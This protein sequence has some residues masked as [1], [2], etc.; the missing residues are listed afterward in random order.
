MERLCILY[1][2]YF[3]AGLKR[4]EGRRVPRGR[5]VKSLTL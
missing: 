4:A 5:A 3:Q 2:C 1:P